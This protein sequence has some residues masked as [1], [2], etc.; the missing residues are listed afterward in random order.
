MSRKLPAALLLSL[1]GGLAFT[2]LPLA[3]PTRAQSPPVYHAEYLGAAVHVAAMNESGLVVGTGSI[4]IY[5]RAW[6]AGPGKP[7][8][9][10]PV[11]FG[12][13]SSGPRDINDQGVIV[14][15]ISPYSTTAFYPQPARWDPD[16]LGGYTVTLLLTLPGDNRGTAEAINNLG[17]IVGTSN[18]QANL[19]TVLYAPTGTVNLPGLAAW[20]PL[21]INDQRVYVSGNARIDLDTLLVE[22]LGV[23]PGYTGAQAWVIN[24][25]GQVAGELLLSGP[26]CSQQ[27]ALYTD[28]LGWTPL[29]DC[30]T[31]DSCYDVNDQGDVLMQLAN[32]PWLHLST[33]GNH[34][35]EDLI[36]SDTGHWTVNTNYNMALNNGRELALYATNGGLSGII[37]LTPESNVVCQA[38]LGFGGPG[39]LQLSLCGG[40]LS[41]G[42]TADL[43]L[44]GA[45]PN[46]LAWLLAGLVQQPTPFKGGTLV[47]VPFALVMPLATDGAGQA[48]ILG[49][50]GGGGSYS[51]V[52]QALQADGAQPKGWALSNAVRADVLP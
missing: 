10:L 41:T 30:G 12:F 34:R 25:G 32:V 38:D 4:G 26:G 3:S 27:V 1:V 8:A 42:T 33:G 11:P 2:L 39:S 36:V 13:L 7:L 9:Y 52:L 49:V 31:S 47:P 22:D 48:S 21:A 17:D 28:G 15:V 40:D 46:G 37:L 19:H 24:A 43:M 29:A 16:G 23:P 14:G 50:P 35:V 20:P 44:T 18:Y 45:L 51:V 5:P 6:V